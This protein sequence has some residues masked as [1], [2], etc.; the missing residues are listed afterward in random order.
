MQVSEAGAD[1]AE[2]R[3]QLDAAASAFIAHYSIVMPK[4]ALTR[5]NLD[6]LLASRD[7]QLVSS[8]SELCSSQGV[9]HV[10]K[11]GTDLLQRPSD[12]ASL[13]W[14]SRSMRLVVLCHVCFHCSAPWRLGPQCVHVRAVVTSHKRRKVAARGSEDGDDA[15]EPSEEQRRA[16]LLRE[17]G[18]DLGGSAK[19]VLTMLSVL[20]LDFVTPQHVQV[21]LEELNCHDGAL[22]AQ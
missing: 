7:K 21:F 14:A 22:R 11:A 16:A 5:G 1:P 18:K 10:R 6:K 12:L 2:Q 8:V 3:Q 13:Q 15:A 20:S 17:V 9:A 4:G 19:D